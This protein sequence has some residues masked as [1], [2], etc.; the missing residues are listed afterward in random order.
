MEVGVG[1]KMIFS[2]IGLAISIILIYFVIKDPKA[3]FE[4]FET[5]SLNFWKGLNIDIKTKQTIFL[6]PLICF[7][8]YL[9][10][11]LLYGFLSKH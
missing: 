2:L 7:S 10:S 9:I 4:I 8:L 1:D 3:V 5:L 11:T 6:I